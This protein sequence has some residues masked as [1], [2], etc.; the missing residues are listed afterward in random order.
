M[1]TEDTSKKYEIL[2][3]YFG[4][5]SF[6]IGQEELIDGILQGKDVVGIMPTGAGKSV[7]YQIP[8]LMLGGVA[9]VIS[10]LISLMHDQVM[11]LVQSG[12]R[13]AYVNSSLTYN[14]YCKVLSNIRNGLYKVIYVAPERLETE[15]FIE[16]CKNIDVS[17]VAVDEA[18]CVSQWGQDFR[19]SYLNIEKFIE[20]L[21]V[22]PVVAAFTATATENVKKDIIKLLSLKDPVCVTTGFDRPNL[23]F[24]VMKPST[25]WVKLLELVRERRALSGIVYCSTRINVEKVCAQLCENGISAVRYHAGLSDEERRQSQEAF[26]YDRASVIVATNAFGMGIDKSN[27]SYI[28]HYNMPK[29]L[30]SYYQEAGRAG[31]DGS[32][33]ECILLYE[34]RDVRTARFLIENSEP[35]DNM[36]EEEQ[37]ELRLKDELK[38]KYMTFYCT[39]NDCLRGYMLRYFGESFTGSCGKCSNC[40]QNYEK[41]DITVEAQKIMSCIARTRQRF[42]VKMICDIL[43]GS[44]NKRI[45]D[46]GFDRLSTFGIMKDCSESKLRSMINSLISLGLIAQDDGQYPVLFLTDKASA[47]LSG[48]Q[49]V[50]T[51]VLRDA[52]P[53]RKGAKEIPSDYELYER[54]RSLRK[55]LADRASVP[56]YVVFSDA[57]LRNICEAKPRSREQ[58]SKISGVGGRKLEKYGDVF[59]REIN[60]Y[61]TEK[62]LKD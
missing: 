38:L 58:F 19:P 56:A 45:T 18:H 10:P 44:S 2:K 3:E 25:K 23:F 16:I 42:G 7:C 50:E 47:V 54:L 9:L 46:L 52:K 57:V 29:D 20:K 11:S 32:E 55:K 8:A 26:V 1:S 13:G 33:A 49:S 30:E 36:T 4:H 14:Q 6:R 28:I 22:R 34:P 35:N 51:K 62:D 24:S 60:K 61:F 39:T 59:I 41:L 5:E 15:S 53:K 43:R 37:R 31:R 40:L 17:L 27:V 48:E 21:P 12:I